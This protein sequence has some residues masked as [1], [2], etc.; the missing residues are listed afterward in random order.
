MRQNPKTKTSITELVPRFQI[1]LNRQ[2]YRR[3]SSDWQE[4]TTNWTDEAAAGAGQFASSHLLLQV[5][6]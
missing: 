4:A 3:F 6:S 5:G 2:L 1:P